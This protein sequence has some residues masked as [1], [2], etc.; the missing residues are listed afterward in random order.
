MGPPLKLPRCL[1]CRRQLHRE[2]VAIC[3]PKCKGPRLK[4][5]NYEEEELR[6]KAIAEKNKLV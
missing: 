4:G 2:G 3:Q 1:L 5:P 6:E